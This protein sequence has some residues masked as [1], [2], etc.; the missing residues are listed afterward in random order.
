MGVIS[1]ATK[2]SHFLFC[3]VDVIGFVA[4]WQNTHT[5][6]NQLDPSWCWICFLTRREFWRLWRYTIHSNDSLL[7]SRA[8]MKKFANATYK[9]NIFAG[10]SRMSRKRRECGKPARY[11]PQ[12]TLRSRATEGHKRARRRL[13]KNCSATKLLRYFERT[14]E[15][16]DEDLPCLSSEDERSD[17]DSP[18]EEDHD[19]VQQPW[20]RVEN[21]VEDQTQLMQKAAQA[22]IDFPNDIKV[23]YP[24]YRCNC[25]HQYFKLANYRKVICNNCR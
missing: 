3:S 4:V 10:S 24:R 6:V 8:L 2:N 17:S 19:Q 13:P 25:C 15:D 22:K 7:P 1:G 5:H 9:P 18:D 12:E 14:Q 11:E 20:R 21:V 16:S 23:E